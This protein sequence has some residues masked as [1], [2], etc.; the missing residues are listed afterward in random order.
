MVWSC[1][2][3]LFWSP[4]LGGRADHLPRASFPVSEEFSRHLEELKRLSLMNWFFFFIYRQL[5]FTVLCRNGFCSA[6]HSVAL[7]NTPLPSREITHDLQVKGHHKVLIKTRFLS[8]LDVPKSSVYIH[9]FSPECASWRFDKPVSYI[10][11]P[12]HSCL[13][14]CGLLS[15]SSSCK[16]LGW[17]MKPD[18]KCQKLLFL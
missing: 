7:S 8:E 1:S 17:T 11:F 5:L 18:W 16:R 2:Q 4:V 15:F 9:C 3:R 14:S 12:K 6:Y 10:S 13:L